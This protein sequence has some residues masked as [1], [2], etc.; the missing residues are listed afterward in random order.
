MRRKILHRFEEGGA[1]AYNSNI[2]EVGRAT[3][4]LT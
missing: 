3:K 4:N 2:M 1:K